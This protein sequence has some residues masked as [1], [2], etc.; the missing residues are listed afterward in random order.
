MA[1]YLVDRHAIK[2][3]VEAIRTEF[4]NEGIDLILSYSIKTNSMPQVLSYMNACNVLPEAVSDMEI[5]LAN[6]FFAK[7]MKISNGVATS[8]K[9]LAELVKAGDIVNVNDLASLK[10]IYQLVGDGHRIGIR[11]RFNDDSRFGISVDDLDKAID[12]CD[13]KFDVECIHCHVTAT[14]E[15]ARYGN[16]VKSM[17]DAL[18]RYDLRPKY[19]DFGGSMYGEL[20]PVL[21]PRFNDVAEFDDY[22]SIISSQIQRLDYKPKVILE[23]GTAL[24][25][26]AVNLVAK[27]IRIDEY[28]RV[29]LDCDKFSLGMLYGDEIPYKSSC[30]TGDEEYTI[31]GC[32]CIEDDVLIKKHV[33]SR[34]CIGDT[35]E[36]VGCGAYTYCFE[37]EFIIPRLEVLEK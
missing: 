29:I 26:N 19:I 14:R 22:A 24:V 34:P 2:R 5:E 12:Y 31:Y 15:K 16:K 35:F 9:N 32:S 18:I 6:R 21:K 20:H 3:N 33:S 37:P 4:D 30:K 1:Y 17:I 11:I 27:V 7:K 36:F 8:Y 25:A 13:G 10:R 23:C 28:D